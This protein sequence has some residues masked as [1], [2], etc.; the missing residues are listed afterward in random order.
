MKLK[1]TVNELSTT[2]ARRDQNGNCTE[3]KLKVVL[4]VRPATKPGGY[5]G[6]GTLVFHAHGDEIEQLNLNLDSRPDV[7]IYPEGYVYDEKELEDTKYENT[8]LKQR[9]EELENRVV[10]Q[11]ANLKDRDKAL[12]AGNR[13]LEI[14]QRQNVELTTKMMTM[15][16][17]IKNNL[18]QPRIDSS[19]GD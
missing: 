2:S 3:K 14:L 6:Y 17:M 10:A 15:E 13:Q 1:S 11:G 9:I 19:I 7:V 4:Q 5:Y 18:S 16:F 12:S 8:Q